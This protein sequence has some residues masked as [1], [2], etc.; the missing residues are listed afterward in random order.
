M[1]LSVLMVRGILIKYISAKFLNYIAVD[2]LSQDLK[3]ASIVD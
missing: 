1:D 2:E 3:G